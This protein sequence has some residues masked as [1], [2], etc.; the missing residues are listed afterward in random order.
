MQV[1]SSS[2]EKFSLKVLLSRYLIFS[3]FQPDVAYKSDA[4][5][6]KSL[7][8]L[9]LQVLVSLNLSKPIKQRTAMQS[10]IYQTSFCIKKGQINKVFTKTVTDVSVHQ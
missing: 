8:P 3:Q 1:L 2:S 4:H 7:Y 9:C 6:T 5:K 10:N